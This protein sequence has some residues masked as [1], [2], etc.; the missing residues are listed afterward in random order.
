[1][2]HAYIALV[3]CAISG[4]VSRQAAFIPWIPTCEVVHVTLLKPTVSVELFEISPASSE[5]QRVRDEMI[6]LVRAG[7]LLSALAIGEAQLVSKQVESHTGSNDEVELAGLITDVSELQQSLQRTR[8]AEAGYLQ[9][10]R[11]YSHVQDQ[12]PEMLRP[13][14][15]LAILYR[16]QGKFEQALPLQRSAYPKLLAW[17]GPDHPDVIE[18]EGELALL[19]L[20]LRQYDEAAALIQARL[21]R[22]RLAEDKVAIA[23]NLKALAKIR[24]AHRLKRARG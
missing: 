2:K 8:S 22:A 16:S 14:V 19:H 23:H 12:Y 7:N 13:A 10:M 11:I 5:R 18:S 20:N 21:D 4:C 17:L 1:M 9:A 3:L 6:A 24:H 15:A